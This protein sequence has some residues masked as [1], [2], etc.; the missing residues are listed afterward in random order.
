MKMLG[1]STWGRDI[2]CPPTCSTHACDSSQHL[3]AYV[4]CTT[5]CF[6]TRPVELREEEPGPGPFFLHTATTF[7]ILTLSSVQENTLQ[8]ISL[9]QL[10]LVVLPSLPPSHNE[11]L[12]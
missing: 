11:N 8:N 12:D 2:K 10:W 1:D 3:T 4:N 7:L 5:W 6:F 9:T